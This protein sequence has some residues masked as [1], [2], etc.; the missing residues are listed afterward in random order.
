MERA[1]YRWWSHP[2]AWTKLRHQRPAF[3]VG[4]DNTLRELAC[5]DMY[6]ARISLVKQKS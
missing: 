6:L 2:D 3:R 1:A 5:L 4:L